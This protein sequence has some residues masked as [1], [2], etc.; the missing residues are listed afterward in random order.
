MPLSRR[1]FAAGGLATL[2]ASSA[3]PVERSRPPLLLLV[4]AEQFRS[5]Y[6]LRW[7]DQFVEGGFRRLLSGGSVYL[8]CRNLAS[9]FT[10]SSLATLATGCYPA[11]H[12]VVANNWFDPARKERV[13]AAQSLLLA[14]TIGDQITRAG[15]R[16]Y[17]VAPEDADA[18]LVTGGSPVN[19]FSMDAR[20]QFVARHRRTGELAW[21]DAFQQSHEPEQV[22]GA[23]WL[24][25]GAQ[26]GSAALRVLEFEPARPEDFYL[27]FKASPF[28]QA[29]TF[30][31]VREIVEHEKVGS[32][33]DLDCLVVITGSTAA[34][35]Y[36]TGADS[37][38]MQQLV[39]HLD[40]SI[41]AT[42]EY[43]DKARGL[44]SYTLA[45]A[46]AHG[47]PRAREKRR[48]ISGE[49]FA[50]AV[51]AA[52]GGEAVERYV[53]P[54]LYLRPGPR[55]RDGRLAAGRSALNVPGVAG[56]FT[57]D[58]DCSHHGGW[59]ERFANSFH[60][61]RCGDVMLAYEPGYVEDYGA[62]HGISYGSLYNYDA[63]TPL[64]FYGPQFAAM[65]IERTVELT[66]V[67]ATL[68]RA[69]ASA[70]P[71]SATGQ[72]LRQAFAPPPQPQ[73]MK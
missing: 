26:P 4:I 60:A 40:R 47:A 23:R 72:V 29:S 34:L 2:A 52:L 64:I 50:R 1:Q 22:R 27:L 43:L 39:L 44:G 62:A 30:D 54:F 20:G 65:R 56:Y 14:T 63:Q 32:G 66:D 15:G 73:E 17:G 71:S 51:D 18:A 69:C 46:G 36:E 33:P 48:S 21:L 70:L 19:V 12:G 61:Q 49:E 57:A 38:L 5:D 68:A 28:A 35:G 41:E 11:T 24:A 45:F 53:Y 42:L 16:V 59:R 3:L 7:R 37:P 55:T 9:T 8:D 25:L 10:A 6:L 58:G 67:A 31:L 13:R